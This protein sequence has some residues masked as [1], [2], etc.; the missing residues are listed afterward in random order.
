MEGNYYPPLKWML[1]APLAGFA[2]NG[3]LGKKLLG[4]KAGGALACLAI[5]VAFIF[6]ALS[7]GDLLNLPPE[8]RLLRDTLY[9]WISAG[10]FSIDAALR[11]DPL[12]AVMAL[13]VTGV[14]FLIHIYST[15]YMKG[16]A[17][18]HRYFAYLNLFVFFMLTLVLADNPVL[19]FVGWE[20]V[21]LCSYLLIGF[22]YEDQQK[23]SAGRKAFI[24]NRVGDAGFLVGLM[25]TYALLASQ[26]VFALDFASLEKNAPLLSSVTVLGMAAPTLICLLLFFGATGKSAQFP[27]HVWLPDAMAGPT[28]VSALIHAAT[29]VTAGVY[30]LARL[31]FLYELAPGALELV[32]LTGCFTAF[33]AA[34]IGLVQKDIKKVLAYSTI[35]QLGY[36]F[37]AAGAG[38]FSASV[39]HLTTHAFFKALLFLAAGSVIHGLHGEQDM[40]KMGGL[41]KEMPVTFLLMA[42][43]ALAIAG[44]PGLSG[45][46]SKDLVLEKVFEHGG[47]L[48]WAIGALTAALTA[49]YITRLFVLTFLRSK[50]GEGQAHESPLSMTVPMAV[51]AVLAVAGGFLL[52]DR[53]LLFLDPASAG[54]HQA[55]EAARLMAVSVAAG[56]AGIAAA[57]VLTVPKT[58][59]ALKSA[60]SPLHSFIF[61][62]FYVDELYGFAI[63]KPLRLLSDTVHRLVDA[64]LIDGFMVNGTAKGSYAAGK[65][66]AKVQNGRL[67]SYALIFA[68]GVA[69]MLF[70]VI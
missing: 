18:Y 66:L 1:L 40:F 2:L 36:M 6:A 12:S 57:F 39:F 5:L 23:A 44:V 16:D 21:G 67:D 58:A 46:Y 32:M 54:A 49:F 70:W 34:V 30:M 60:L 10:T 9:N 7:F 8:N 20:G 24:T 64:G 11:F 35:S 37:M 4:E 41:K 14:S 48:V 33:F 47:P 15:G 52:K 68:L 13:V 63:F 61:H 43:G 25:L 45:F 17:G 38:A 62:K 56:L 42:A 19:M 3:L 51:L 53:L 69:L 31:H 29:M 27:L 50:K 22:W 59:A 55:P 26:G 28:P 65:L